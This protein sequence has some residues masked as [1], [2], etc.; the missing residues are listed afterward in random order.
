MPG[1]GLHHPAATDPLLEISKG[2][3]P[4]HSA[5]NKFGRNPDCDPASSTT[6]VPVGRDIWDGG[7][8]GAAAW[9]PPTAARTHAIAS[10]DDEDGG[11]GTDT[12]ALTMRVFGLDSAYAL[13]QEDVTLNGTS[14][15]NTANT[16]TMIHR[17]YVLTAGSAGRNLGNIT[18][19]AATDGTVTAQIT[20]DMNQTLMAIYQIPAGKKGYMNHWRGDLNKTGGATKFADFALMSKDDGAVWRVRETTSVGSDGSTHFAIDITPPKVLAAKTIVKIVADPSAV[21]Q[22]IGAGFDIILVDG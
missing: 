12:G 17:M 19:T 5:I 13:Q 1:A 22:D 20:I 6:A 8:A 7:V 4:G 10:S 11:A 14:N 16:Y 9:V 3:V 21:A 18:A 15:V 2:T